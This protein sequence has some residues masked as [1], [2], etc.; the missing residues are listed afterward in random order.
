LP[1]T[2]FDSLEPLA[3]VGRTSYPAGRAVSVEP[4]LGRESPV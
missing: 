1:P 2:R 3:R 4:L